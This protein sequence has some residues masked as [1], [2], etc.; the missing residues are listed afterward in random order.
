MSAS[1]RPLRKVARVPPLSRA[2]LPVDPRTARERPVVALTFAA[3]RA[4]GFSASDSAVAA[5]P[6]PL[7]RGRS[8]PPAA[9]RERRSVDL[10]EVLA[11]RRPQKARGHA[12]GGAV[13]P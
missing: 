3:P 11:G 10:G 8:A 4:L 7:A 6:W 2:A 5:R 9:D 1:A 12:P 13:S